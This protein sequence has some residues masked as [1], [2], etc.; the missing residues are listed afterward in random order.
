MIILENNVP[1]LPKEVL[2]ESHD[3][4]RE[5]ARLEQ[6]EVLVTY[7]IE[8]EHMRVRVSTLGAELRSIL[9]T[10][11]VEYLWQSDPA[12]WTGRSP[13]LFPFVGRFPASGYTIDGQPNQM[14]IH[15]F[16]SKSLFTPIVVEKDRLV[17]E[18]TDSEDTL[19]QYPRHFS[20]RVEY[21]LRERTLET[22]FH[23]LN[24]DE[25][26]MYFGLGGHPGFRVPLEEGLSFED[27]R[28]ELP[29]AKDT[30][31]VDFSENLLVSGMSPYAAEKGIELKHSIFDDDA[32]VLYGAGHTVRLCSS[33]G[34]RE[35]TVR[36]PGMDYVGFW[37]RPCTDAPYVCIEPWCSLPADEGKLLAFEE[38]KD[39]ICLEPGKE[40]KN[41]WT[42]E[43][44]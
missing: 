37:H 17:L 27:Y 44:G 26:T 20:F 7:Q 28:L 16:A 42:I 39:L 40:Y 14:K 10:N 5:L 35:L 41:L 31:I 23:V 25:K 13:I 18:L 2:A 6:E 43:I 34:G 38:K 12:Y 3:D 4:P 9:G 19:S 21:A 22:T 1:G 15:G 11:G 8:N 24:R 30:K 36:F 32:I 29:E 33:K